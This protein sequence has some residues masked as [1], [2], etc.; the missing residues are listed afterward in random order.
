MTPLVQLITVVHSTEVDYYCG[1]ITTHMGYRCPARSHSCIHNSNQHAVWRDISAP[2]SNGQVD[3]ELKNKWLGALLSSKL[4]WD[5]LI[6][7]WGCMFTRSKWRQWHLRWLPC[8]IR[9]SCPVDEKMRLIT[10]HLWGKVETLYLLVHWWSWE[11][12]LDLNM[13]R[14]QPLV[15]Q[16]TRLP[17]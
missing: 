14:P 11:D 13:V 17:S 3:G 6:L 15:L 10:M 4:H 1:C 9:H 12:S 5:N 8:M 7:M 16:L 2:Q